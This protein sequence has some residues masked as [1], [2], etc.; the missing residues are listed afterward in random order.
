LRVLGIPA[1]ATS[2]GVDP[3]A[4]YFLKMNAIY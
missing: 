1:N 2:V 3:L 4:Y